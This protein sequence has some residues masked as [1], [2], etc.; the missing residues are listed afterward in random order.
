[1]N[2][3]LIK[4][5]V[6]AYNKEYKNIDFEFSQ[7]DISFKLSIM[8]NNLLENEYSIFSAEINIFNET[9]DYTLMNYGGNIVTHQFLK[10]IKIERVIDFI[11]NSLFLL[12]IMPPAGASRNK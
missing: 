7:E 2:F 12:E 9:L 6:E 4:K 11:D 3:D 5:K 8:R 1:M 10:E